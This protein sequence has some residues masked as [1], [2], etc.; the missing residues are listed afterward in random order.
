VDPADVSQVFHLSSSVKFRK[1]AY[2]HI[3]IEKIKHD[4]NLILYNNGNNNNNKETNIKIEK[5]KG[6]YNPFCS[7]QRLSVN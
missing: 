7:S 1:L 2:F 4:R 6:F 5:W 3:A